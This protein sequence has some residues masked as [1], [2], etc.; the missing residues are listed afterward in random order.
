MPSS[1]M[2]EGSILMGVGTATFAISC[3]LVAGAGMLWE[4]RRAR[5]GKQMVHLQSEYACYSLGDD[6]FVQIKL[7]GRRWTKNLRGSWMDSVECATTR[8]VDI[9]TL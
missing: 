6:V 7:K 5:N 1:A 8:G 2:A 3:F 9:K 4:G